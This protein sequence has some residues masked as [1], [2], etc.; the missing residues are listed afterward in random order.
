[1]VKEDVVEVN[2]DILGISEVKW[3]GKGELPQMCVCKLTP[4]KNDLSQYF[5]GGASGKESA[6]QC[7]RHVR[8]RF[9]P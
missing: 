4:S 1:M 2:I 7:K 5:L 3:T 8:L 6:C 9:E